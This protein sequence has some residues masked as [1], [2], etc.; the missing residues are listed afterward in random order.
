VNNLIK[1]NCALDAEAEAMLPF[2]KKNDN[3]AK[4][5]QFDLSDISVFLQKEK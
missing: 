2:R 1:K 5:R 3:Q 4:Q